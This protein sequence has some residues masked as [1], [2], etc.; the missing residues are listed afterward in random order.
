[1]FLC[2]FV[3]CLFVCSSVYW[4]WPIK[5]GEVGNSDAKL[6]ESRIA[7]LESESVILHLDDFL[8]FSTQDGVESNDV[9]WSFLNLPQSDT[10]G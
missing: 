8:A 9:T 6:P 4:G 5:D 10:W 3:I 1:M 7:I 2:L